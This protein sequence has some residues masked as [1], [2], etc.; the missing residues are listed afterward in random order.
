MSIERLGL[1]S[2]G[3]LF[4]ALQSQNRGPGN[5]TSAI[6][7]RHPVSD[8]LDGLE[9]AR[10]TLERR[11]LHPQKMASSQETEVYLFGL[12]RELPRNLLLVLQ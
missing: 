1:I 12:Q 9:L 10:H 5:H 4:E 8:E 2:P 3:V 11:N 6:C 7:K